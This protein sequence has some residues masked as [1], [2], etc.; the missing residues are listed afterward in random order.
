MSAV[1]LYVAKA[2]DAASAEFVP[3]Q[4]FFVATSAANLQSMLARPEIQK[5]NRGWQVDLWPPKPHSF[6]KQLERSCRVLCIDL[7]ACAPRA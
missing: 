7:V 5:A 4:R 1:Q 6:L 3:N 2:W